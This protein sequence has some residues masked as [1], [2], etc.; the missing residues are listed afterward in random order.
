MNPHRP[1]A[2]SFPASV[3][4]LVLLACAAVLLAACGDQR[5]LRAP[6]LPADATVLVV[7]DSLVAGTGA[8]RAQSW[9]AM[10]AEATGWSVINAGVPGHTS[11]DARGRLRGLLDQHHPDAVII[12]IGGNDFLRKHNL[13]GTRANIEAML[14]ESKAATGHVALVAIPEPS[15]GGQLLGMLS[16]HALYAGLAE[17]HAVTLIPDAVAETLSRDDYR[18]DRIHANANGYAYLAGRVA[19]VLAEAGWLIR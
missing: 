15:M 18:A 12:A 7:G 3:L 17:A 19:D 4:R 11:A 6:A 8:T 2:V 5:P 14:A 10:L 9:P 16:D 13:D 1:E